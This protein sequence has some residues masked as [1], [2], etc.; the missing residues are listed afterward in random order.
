MTQGSIFFI[1][2]FFGFDMTNDVAS[3]SPVLMYDVI[4]NTAE[5]DL[6]TCAQIIKNHLECEYNA[7]QK[8]YAQTALWLLNEP[9]ELCR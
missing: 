1:L 2:K 8:N 3:V 4:V 6:V 5:Q 9:L 7:H